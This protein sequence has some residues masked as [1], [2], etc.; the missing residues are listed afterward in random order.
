MCVD[1]IR[2]STILALTR[3]AVL[4]A[5]ACLACGVL[6][7]GTFARAATRAARGACSNHVITLL[8]LN[9]ELRVRRARAVH[10]CRALG[11]RLLAWTACC[12]RLMIST[13]DIRRRTLLALTPYALLPP[14]TSRACC[15]LSVG[16]F[17]R[18]ATRAARGHCSHHVITFLP[19]N[20]QHSVRR[21][22]AIA[23]CRALCLRRPSRVPA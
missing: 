14:R 5:R 10:A 21:A 15:V 11:V 1:N 18:T 9:S 20:S 22:R 12:A 2:L 6:S 7:V 17:A 8:T 3:D 19:L 4:R 16:A 23:A 13:H